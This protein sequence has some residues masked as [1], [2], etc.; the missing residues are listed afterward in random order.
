MDDLIE[1]QGWEEESLTRAHSMTGQ[2]FSP[3]ESAVV[4]LPAHNNTHTHKHTF[5]I[6]RVFVITYKSLRSRDR[7]EEAKILTLSH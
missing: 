5:S 2:S 3:A 6:L 1:R 4:I 7:E